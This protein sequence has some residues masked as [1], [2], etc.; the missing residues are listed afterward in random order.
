MFQNLRSLFK[1]GS[2]QTVPLHMNLWFFLDSKWILKNI[3]SF[4]NHFHVTKSFSCYKIIF[5]S[6]NHF[7]VTNLFCKSF[8]H[9]K[10]IFMSQNHFANHFHVTKSFSCH[11][12][13]FLK[14]FSCYKIIFMSQNHFSLFSSYTLGVRFNIIVKLL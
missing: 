3:F 5:I 6:Q 11:K 9:Y 10:I 12:I 7:H 1:V 2:L 8:S 13:I 14:S 4:Q